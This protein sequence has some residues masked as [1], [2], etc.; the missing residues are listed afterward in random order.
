MREQSQR[1]QSLFQG[2]RADQQQSWLSVCGPTIYPLNHSKSTDW[3]GEKFEAEMSMLI[4][5]RVNSALSNMVAALLT[6]CGFSHL[7]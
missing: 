6:T 4:L 2:L 7:N 1:V 5:E 3:Q